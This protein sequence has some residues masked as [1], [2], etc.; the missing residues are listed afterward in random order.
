MTAMDYQFFPGR[1]TGSHDPASINPNCSVEQIVSALFEEILS[2]REA[3]RRFGT[4]LMVLELHLK[5]HGVDGDSV[6]RLSALGLHEAMLEEEIENFR[7]AL[8]DIESL[9]RELAVH[10]A[11]RRNEP[12]SPKTQKFVGF[13]AEMRNRFAEMRQQHADRRKRNA[14]LASVTKGMGS[15]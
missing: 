13:I 14:K 1:R 4:A 11:E 3:R 6:A 12:V 10:G 5:R 8:A 7:D 9:R 15:P 2:I